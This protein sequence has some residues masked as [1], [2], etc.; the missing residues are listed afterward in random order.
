MAEKEKEKG[1]REVAP[2]R[3]FSEMARLEGEMEQIF[4]N[5]FGRRRRLPWPQRWWPGRAAGVVVASVDLYEDGDEVVAKVELPGLSKEDVQVNI[6][7][8]VLTIKGEK[9]K[10]EEVKEEDYYCAERSYGSFTRT[11]ELP[12]AVQVDK[13]KASF[14]DGVLEIRLP[15]TEEAKKREIKVKV[16]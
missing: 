11:L 2:W 12:K 1:T 3:P 13:A 16:D 14:K 7:D 4:D 8:H 6:T 9:K 5:F 10:E 15:K